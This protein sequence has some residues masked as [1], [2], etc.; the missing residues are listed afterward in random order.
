ME[1]PG[2]LLSW[3]EELRAWLRG[4]DMDAWIP[5][6]ARQGNGKSTFALYLAP[7]LDPTFYHEPLEKRVAF[8]GPGG[9]EILDTLDPFQAMV[10]DEGTEGFWRRNAI[11]RA[12]KDVLKSVYEDRKK[13]HI[14]IPLFPDWQELDPDFSEHRPEWRFTLPRKGLATCLRA[15]RKNG[16]RIIA[17]KKV[18]Q[19]PFPS[20]KDT[21]VWD[22]YLELVD[23][24]SHHARRQRGETNGAQRPQESPQDVIRRLT[25]EYE[26]LLQPLAE[27]WH[28]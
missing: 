5:I 25:G 1:V 26:S 20:L 10:F 22:A 21:W 14:K 16:E 2:V 24:K 19:V 6:T 8:D 17:W 11:T 4:E 3:A 28:A 15:K 9:L 12:N 23:D 27:Q 7:L 13:N 18:F